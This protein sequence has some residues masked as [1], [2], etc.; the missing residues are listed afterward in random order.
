MILFL[1]V[2][3]VAG[4]FL[5]SPV[6]KEETTSIKP[7]YSRIKQGITSSSTLPGKIKT[8]PDAPPPYKAQNDY[9]SDTVSE[10]EV[11]GSVGRL[12]GRL[13]I[14]IDDMG[15]S[16]E[17]ARLLAGIKVPLTFAI[18]PGLRVDKEV[19]TYA[20]GNNIE[21]I[22]HI[23]MQSK[24]WP[25]RRLEANGLLVSMDADELQERVSRFVQEFPGAV[26]CN[27][28]TGSE[29][30]EHEEK[31]KNVLLD[32]KKNNLFFVDS[33]TSPDSVGFRVAQQLGVKS[34]RRNVFL[35]NE[36]ERGYI[37][38]QLNQAVRMARK[39]GSAI[40]ICHPHPA[41]IAALAAALPALTRQGVKLVPVSQLVK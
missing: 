25:K 10:T 41:T 31:M 19:A 12:S 30:T 16:M 39:N 22:I 17:E 40:A 18:I 26:G 36:Q 32:L 4:Y 9:P 1:V 20:A 29:F 5:F 28:H 27:N 14:I 6:R 35:D 13:A 37:L 23:P 38:G 33:L 21:T 3:L 24:E 2:S 7:E 34:A 8:S 11:S 15:S